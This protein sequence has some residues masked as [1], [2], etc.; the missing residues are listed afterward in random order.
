MGVKDLI[1]FVTHSRFAT[2]RDFLKRFFKQK[3][4]QLFILKTSVT[5]TRQPTTLLKIQLHYLAH[6]CSQQ[7]H[8]Q[9]ASNFIALYTTYLGPHNGC[10]SLRLC[11]IENVE[12]ECGDQTGTLRKR[13]LGSNQLSSRISLSISF[14]FK[15]PL[16]GNTTE[17]DRNQTTEEIS[18]NLLLKFK[19][20]TNRSSER[21]DANERI[22]GEFLFYVCQVL[23]YNYEIF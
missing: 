4:Q 15:I 2:F 22:A 10:D 17:A 23:P 16:P 3:N 1:P 6:Q 14:D 8:Q 7:I 19:F 12:V 18:S 13:D 9:I 20:R 21:H 11:T 5:E